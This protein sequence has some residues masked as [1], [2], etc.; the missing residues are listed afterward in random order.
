L[1]S[2]RRTNSQSARRD[3]L[4]RK[5]AMAQSHTQGKLPCPTMHNR[6]QTHSPR[7]SPARWDVPLVSTR[8]EGGHGM[9]A[10]LLHVCGQTPRS[11][12][13]PPRHLKDVMSTPPRGLWVSRVYVS[14]CPPWA[15]HAWTSCSARS[16]ASNWSRWIMTYVPSR[17]AL[18][19]QCGSNAC[20]ARP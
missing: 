15:N 10:G 17:G 20:M 12:I 1:T 8:C 19:S 2:E 9:Q 5:R 3:K 11:A 13:L 6:R 7:D 4:N 16:T 14:Q 18:V